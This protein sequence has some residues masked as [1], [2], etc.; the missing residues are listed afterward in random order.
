MFGD[1]VGSVMG[2]CIVIRGSHHQKSRHRQ[3][4][5]KAKYPETAEQMDEGCSDRNLE[6]TVMPLKLPKGD[7]IPGIVYIEPSGLPASVSNSFTANGRGKAKAGSE[8]PTA[9]SA[10]ELFG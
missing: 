8:P 5:E 1:V 10:T 2:G 3:R 7:L 6:G 9:E 4:T